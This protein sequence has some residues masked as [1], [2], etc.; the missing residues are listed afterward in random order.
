MRTTTTPHGSVL[1]CV[2][3]HVLALH[4]LLWIQGMNESAYIHAGYMCMWTAVAD[5]CCRKKKGWNVLK[6]GAMLAK[7]MG[8]CGVDRAATAGTYRVT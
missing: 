1:H 4:V 7:Y 2:A 8:T 5:D 3:H 6:K